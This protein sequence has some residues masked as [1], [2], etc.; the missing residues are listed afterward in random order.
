MTNTDFLKE[1]DDDITVSESIPYC[2]ITNPDNLSLSQIKQFNIPWGVFIPT[3]QAELVDL[4]VPDDFTPT[5]LTFDQ[6]KPTERHIDGFLAQHIRFSLIHRSSIEVQEKGANG[7]QYL[8]EAY[9]KGKITKYG[10]LA[11]KDRESYRLRT[12]YL[13]LFLDENNEPLHRVPLR[14]GLGA[15]TG[16]SL[17]EEVKVFRGE[18]ERVFF[19]LRQQPQKALS[20]KAHALTVLD[21]QLGVHKGDGKAPFVCPSVRLA[22]AIDQVGKEKVADRKGDRKVKL[23]GTPIQDLMLPKSSQTGQL[24]LSLWD[25][26]QDFPTKYQDDTNGYSEQ[27]TEE[28]Y[29][30]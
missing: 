2:Q 5:H 19:K 28:D 10:E 15:G 23:V 13:I 8:G 18:I 22:P 20:D 26:Y 4:T 21:I 9:K 25:E 27:E 16:G 30:F 17:G 1:F 12:R 14:L 29:D 3:D 6:D 11:S 7:W 24:I